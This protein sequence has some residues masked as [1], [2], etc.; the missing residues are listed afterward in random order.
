MGRGMGNWVWVMGMGGARQEPFE[1]ILMM[2]NQI[3]SFD[4]YFNYINYIVPSL[5][6]NCGLYYRN[7]AY[8]LIDNRSET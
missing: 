3:N 6:I 4:I 8:S 2:E 7:A 5:Y 1:Y